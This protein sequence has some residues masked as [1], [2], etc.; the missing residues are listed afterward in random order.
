MP[1]KIDNYRLRIWL[2]DYLR[3]ARATA[4]T[5]K[6]EAMK[7]DPKEHN[8]IIVG[9]IDATVAILEANNKATRLLWELREDDK[10][11]DLYEGDDL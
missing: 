11:A 4:D 3:N 8:E 10:V 5:L 1:S 9:I 6:E 7:A 2:E